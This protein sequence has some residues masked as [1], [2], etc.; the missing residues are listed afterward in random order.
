MTPTTAKLLRRSINPQAS[1]SASRPTL[2]VPCARGQEHGPTGV[3]PKP[4][5]F[6]VGVS[7]CLT[8]LLRTQEGREE[9]VK[10]IVIGV[11]TSD[12]PSEAPQPRALDAS[13]QSRLSGPLVTARPSLIWSSPEST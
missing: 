2:R 8:Y 5:L 7:L 6:D 12:R 3:K 4:A 11:C 1:Y 10:L 9:K 13:V